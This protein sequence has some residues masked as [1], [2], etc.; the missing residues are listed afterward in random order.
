MAVSK[1]DNRNRMLQE[2]GL[3]YSQIMELNEKMTEA[4]QNAVDIDISVTGGVSDIT[5][6]FMEGFHYKID[7]HAC[8][9][10]EQK[11]WEYDQLPPVKEAELEY[12]DTDIITQG[13]KRTITQEELNRL[14]KEHRERQ[15]AGN[16]ETLDLSNCIFNRVRFSGKLS[17]ISLMGSELND[18][19]FENVEMEDSYLYKAEF[20]NTLF[21]DCTFDHTIFRS[22]EMGYCEMEYT[23]YTDCVFAES[24]IVA[25]EMQSSGMNECFLEKAIVSD[26]KFTDTI[27][28]KCNGMEFIDFSGVDKNLRNIA[29][30]TF[31]NP[32]YTFVF[33]IKPDNE[34]TVHAH[35]GQDV[36]EKTFQVD[37]NP[38]T[39]KIDKISASDYSLPPEKSSLLDR[40][41]DMIKMDIQKEF[42]RQQFDRREIS[43][44]SPCVMVEMSEITGLNN[45]TLYDVKEFSEKLESYGRDEN[46]NRIKTNIYDKIRYTVAFDIGDGYGVRKWED[47]YYL[48]EDKDS[49]IERLENSRRFNNAEISYLKNYINGEKLPAI[50]TAKTQA[51]VQKPEEAVQ[52]KATAEQR[53]PVT[54][55]L[56][57]EKH[58][59]IAPEKYAAIVYVKGKSDVKTRVTG[60]SPEKII[61]LCQK[62]NAER[63][64]DD[65]LGTAYIKKYNPTTKAYDNLGKYDISKGTEI[66]ASQ[67]PVYLELPPLGK[68]EFGKM[69]SELKANGARFNPELKKWYVTQSC[70]LS[71]FAAYLPKQSEPQIDTKGQSDRKNSVLNGL[72]QNKGHLDENKQQGK[73]PQEQ[74]RKKDVPER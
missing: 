70:D 39:H 72:N 48:R 4:L 64:S 21:S 41:V 30:N 1:L 10:S 69:V 38:D 46:I 71:K 51:N 37:Y 22:A 17:G 74:Q 62:W 5:K 19:T 67:P 20:M 34:V 9:V 11:K 7:K 61:Q 25:C 65:Q 26:T 16:Y 3:I 29:E 63:A 2:M 18:C 55:K 47:K 33:E 15:E 14:L 6:E 45:N 40:A 8:V 54:Q 66:P 59:T 31:N 60:T 36:I 42:Q 68:Q 44:F 27:I 12:Q 23:M 32:E 57:N 49:L 35:A 52:Q 56:Q 43:R 13:D 53:A 24:A 28:N 73:Q 50:E 58:R